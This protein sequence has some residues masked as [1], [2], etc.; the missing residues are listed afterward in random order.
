[1]LFLRQ[2]LSYRLSSLLELS[3]LLLLHSD[4]VVALDVVSGHRYHHEW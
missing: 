2:D 3:I 1:M 4:V